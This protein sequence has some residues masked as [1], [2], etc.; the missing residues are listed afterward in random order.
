MG[1]G[2][3]PLL[4]QG[5][6]SPHLKFLLVRCWGPLS[7]LAPNVLA[8]GRQ[9]FVVLRLRGEKWSI[10]LKKGQNVS[11]GGQECFGGRQRGSLAPSGLSAAEEREHG[12]EQS[13]TSL[14]S[15]AKCC[16]FNLSVVL[17]K[18]N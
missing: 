18:C 14:Q 8:S 2:V 5:F 17:K 16:D 7:A 13:S 6:P 9:T 11:R 12:I 15:E 3:F 10:S 1:F 4:I